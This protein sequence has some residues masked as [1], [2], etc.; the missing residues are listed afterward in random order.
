VPR[1]R[2][3][4]LV[5]AA[6]LLAGLFVRLGFWQVSRYHERVAANRL[7]AT[8][9]AEPRLEWAASEGAEVPADTAGLV[10]RRVRVSGRYDRA[11]EVVLRGRV[12]EGQPGVEVLTPLIVGDGA[13]LVLRGW[14][15]SPDALRV[16]LAESWPQTWNDS[17]T[18]T[19][20][21][22]LIPDAIGRAGQPLTF[23]SGGREYL[24][25]AGADL[26]II[27]HA[28]PYP[29]RPQIVRLSDGGPGIAALEERPVAEPG[30]GPHAGY[31]IQWFSFAL[32]SLV[33]T[34]ILVRKER[35][36]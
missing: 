17:A 1:P 16:D 26:E 30:N 2:T 5:V 35:T 11:H 28:L 29:L 36:A 13:I 14:M 9:E 15:A 25:L 3:I 24:V 27:G 21:G 23:E 4:I 6:V 22:T 18:V 7:R 8:R 20:E 34:G 31:A 32:I 33:G 10:W 12:F 19:V